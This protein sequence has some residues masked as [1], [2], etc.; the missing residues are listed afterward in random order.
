M[1]N[2]TKQARDPGF[3]GHH[4]ARTWL[5]FLFLL[6]IVS[7]VR[8]ESA[9]AIGLP[10][11]GHYRPGKYMP[12]RVSGDGMLAADGAVPVRVAGQGGRDVI[13]PLL[14]VREP[15]R[16]L[17]WTARGGAAS[18]D[19]PLAPLHDDEVLVGFA[20]A[21]ADALRP[22]LAGKTIVGVPLDLGHPIAGPAV[23][24]EA[25]DGIV[26]D[27][28][29]AARID[30]GQLRDLLAGGTAVAVRSIR[31][32][33]GGW[34]WERQGEYWVVRVPVQGPS[35]AYAP[36]AYAP[37]AAWLRGWPATVRRQ[38]VL[39]AILFSL[40]ALGL[41]LWRSLKAVLAIVALSA[42]T[43]GGVAVWRAKQPAGLAA[44]GA[45]LVRGGPVTQRDDWTY[46]AVLRPATQSF[47]FSRTTRPVLG[48]RNQIA[49]TDLQL[50]CREDGTPMRFD[51]RLEPRQSLAFLNRSVWPTDAGGPV[52][53]P[54]SSPLRGTADALY[55]TKG[56]RMAGQVIPSD[57]SDER[58]PAVVIE[59]ER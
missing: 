16:N 38:V 13:V 40:L 17:K 30:E 19:V 27:A 42:G 51:F 48:Y 5:T 50:V 54:V 11:Q 26:L 18:I 35:Q 21:D 15:L 12:V 44:G 28:A 22:L 41:S 10:L 53:N 2:V 47:A 37:T 45:V 36:A 25:L 4:P 59:R 23:A 39:T 49:Q 55:M 3:H 56:D 52:T 24:W 6:L 32:P 46:C 14:A 43:A 31:R 57:V 20:D 1:V 33:G 9:P 58:W 29:A 7:S 34:P 8:A